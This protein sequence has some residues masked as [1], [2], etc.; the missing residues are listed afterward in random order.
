MEAYGRRSAGYTVMGTCGYSV[1]EVARSAHV[2]VRTLHHYD[3]I[4]LLCPSG[5]TTSG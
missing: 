5:R 2:T 1:G 4:G 3:E